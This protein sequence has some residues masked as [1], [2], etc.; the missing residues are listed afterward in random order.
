MKKIQKTYIVVALTVVLVGVLLGWYI[1][2]PDWFTYGNERPLIEITVD[3]ISDYFKPNTGI[4]TLKP[5]QL[6]EIEGRIKKINTLNSRHTILLK[7]AL[8]Q[9]PYIICDMQRGQEKKLEWLKENDT[10]RVKGV[11]KGFL[12]DAVF[13]NCIVT[14][15]NLHE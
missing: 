12:K 10:I 2:R 1:N 13:L 15:H 8:D 4:T 11:F 6:V 3:N 7:G 9:S 14:H 5:E